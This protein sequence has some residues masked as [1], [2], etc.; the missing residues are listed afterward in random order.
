M[1]HH[2]YQKAI[3]PWKMESRGPNFPSSSETFRKSKKIG[4][5]LTVFLGD[6][7]V[8]GIY[9]PNNTWTVFR[10]HKRDF[11]TLGPYY[12]PS[13][14]S[15]KNIFYFLDTQPFWAKSGLAVLEMLESFIHWSFDLSI[16]QLLKKRSF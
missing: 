3:S 12:P 10:L 9:L 16:H 1:C 11:F 8:A 2:F 7:E 5:Y 13:L 14:D 6:L 4:F 15:A